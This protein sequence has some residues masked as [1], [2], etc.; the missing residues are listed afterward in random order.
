VS[1]LRWW[2]A[3]CHTERAAGTTLTSSLDPRYQIGS[4]RACGT[5]RAFEQVPGEVLK[6]EGIA[7]VERSIG[8]GVD[9]AWNQKARMEVMALISL[10]R[11]FTATEI[12]D[13]AGLPIHR[14]AVG[15]LVN[16]LAREGVIRKVGFVN[17]TR[18]SQHARTIAVWEAA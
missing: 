14:N 3:A 7:R 9:A 13:R 10:G 17:G 12:T 5:T 6:A 8:Q 16:S 4:C 11:P 1:D 15:A 18:Q 2:C